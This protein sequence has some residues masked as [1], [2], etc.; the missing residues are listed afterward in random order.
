[1][2]TTLKIG[3]EGKA[4]GSVTTKELGALLNRNGI[5]VEFSPGVRHHLA[6]QGYSEEFGARELRRLIKR[7]IEDRVTAAK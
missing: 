3:R 6:R 5:G 7:Q 2:F 1:M 4:F